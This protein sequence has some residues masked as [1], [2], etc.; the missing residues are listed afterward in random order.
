MTVY[1]EKM[2]LRLAAEFAEVSEPTMRIWV[3][4]IPNVEKNPTGGYL[5][6]RDDLTAYLR[7]KGGRKMGATSRDIIGSNGPSQHNEV[8]EGLKRERDRAE[9]EAQFLRERV[10]E[11]EGLVSRMAAD[12]T[13]L[14]REFFEVALRGA[15]PGLS[16]WTNKIREQHTPKHSETVDAELVTQPIAKPVARSRAKIKPKK[17]AKVMKKKAK[18]KP[19]KKKSVSKSSK[20]KR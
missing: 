2:S 6:P 17:V 15:T 20:R 10:K 13:S 5:I 11:L 19:A 12:L 18:V 7:A 16:S 14:S 3:K 9:L 1:G 4:E 8:V